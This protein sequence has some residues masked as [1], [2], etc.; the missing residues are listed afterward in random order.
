MARTPSEGTVNSP[1]SVATGNVDEKLQRSKAIQVPWDSWQYSRPSIFLW[2]EETTLAYGGF[3]LQV[4]LDYW[5]YL[6]AY[7]PDD[8]CLITK[9]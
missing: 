2:L 8:L 6:G 4:S 9:L 3:L 1:M 5:N 7:I